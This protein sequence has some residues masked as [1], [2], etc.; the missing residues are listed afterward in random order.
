MLSS[1][2]SQSQS[3]PTVNPKRNFPAP[4]RVFP[5]VTTRLHWGFPD[6]SSFQGTQEEKLAKTREVRDTIKAKIEA[7]CEEICCA[8]SA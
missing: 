3:Q 7:W 5:G 6:P 2:G 1:H 4:S 8:T